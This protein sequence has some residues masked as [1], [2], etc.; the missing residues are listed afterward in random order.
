MLG[1][2]RGEGVGEGVSMV[3]FRFGGFGGGGEE[4]RMEIGIGRL[5]LGDWDWGVGA[6]LFVL[7]FWLGLWWFGYLRG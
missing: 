7:G 5:G 1:S 3:G 2:L 6:C 4:G